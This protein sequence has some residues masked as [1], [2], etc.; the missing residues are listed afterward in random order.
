MELLANT[1]ME[2]IESEKTFNKILSRLSSI[3]YC[4]DPQYLDVTYE[5]ASTTN[6]NNDEYAMEVDAKSDGQGRKSSPES[7]HGRN[8]YRSDATG[9]DEARQILVRVRELLQVSDTVDLL[10]WYNVSLLTLCATV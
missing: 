2:F 7:T 9:D 6:T 3:L 4:D 10:F 5:R 1:S 8:G